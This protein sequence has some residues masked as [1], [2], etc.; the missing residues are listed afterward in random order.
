MKDSR[1]EAKAYA[2]KLL[3][4]RSRS[5]KEMLNKLERKGFSESHIKS[6]IDFLEASGLLDDN[7][8]ASE[9]L[10][11]SREKKHLGKLGIRM[12]MT[13]RGLG[14]ELIDR[15]LSGH[16]A[17]IEEETAREFI[18]NKLRTMEHYPGRII[19]R[20]IWGMLRRRGF[21]FEV[22]NRVIKSIE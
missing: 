6:T 4:Y 14:N 18:N 21:S 1:A 17:E 13:E 9:L 19:R 20:K 3:G 12:F 11:Y 15:S 5:R 8:L 22:M 10:R 7:T 16:S 2:L